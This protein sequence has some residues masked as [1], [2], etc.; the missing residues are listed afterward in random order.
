M[1]VIENDKRDKKSPLTQSFTQAQNIQVV[2]ASSPWFEVDKVNDI[3]YGELVAN[4]Y[5]RKFE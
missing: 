2:K 3:P 1:D 4:R 5:L